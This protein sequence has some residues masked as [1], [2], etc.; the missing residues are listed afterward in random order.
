MTD[1]RTPAPIGAAGAAERDEELVIDVND[2]YGAARSAAR[3]AVADGRHTGDVAA[4][5]APAGEW[6]ALNCS[7]LGVFPVQGALWG[8]VEALRARRITADAARAAAASEDGG[9]ADGDARATAL[10]WIADALEHDS[11]SH[12]I[13]IEVA[14]ALEVGWM[15]EN[16]RIRSLVVAI[17]E[18]ATRAAAAP[19][20][21]S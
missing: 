7:W 21:A 14:E 1:D 11:D 6:D 8:A 5:I 17:V 16:V 4:D 10:Q 9:A 3:R 2:V 13:D 19:R 20:S 12:N 18:V 15:R